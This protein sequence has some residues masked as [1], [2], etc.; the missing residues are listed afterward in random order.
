MISKKPVPLAIAALALAAPMLAQQASM[1]SLG[2]QDVGRITGGTYKVDNE[3]TLVGWEVDH[4]G[5]TP[6]FGTFGQ[7]SGNLVLDPKDP[8]AS[9]F[10]IVIP[11]ANVL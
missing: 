8:V 1:P 9:K 10:D 4:L 7:V 2:N 5:V 11:I 3:H 6:Y